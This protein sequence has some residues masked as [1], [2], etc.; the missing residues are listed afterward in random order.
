MVPLYQDVQGVHAASIMQ[1][2]SRNNVLPHH[3]RTKISQTKTDHKAF[4]S[5]TPLGGNNNLFFGVSGPV[6][7]NYI[8]LHHSN[9]AGTLKS[10][11]DL[12]CP[13]AVLRPWKRRPAGHTAAVPERPRFQWSPGVTR[14]SMWHKNSFILINFVIKIKNLMIALPREAIHRSDVQS[15]HL[16]MQRF[17]PTGCLRGYLLEFNPPRWLKV[18]LLY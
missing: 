13:A 16:Q 5:S 11:R 9:G 1:Y 15:P 4:P 10:Q 18:R 14:R 8:V 2:L 3:R 6:Y 7:I 17:Q 12:T